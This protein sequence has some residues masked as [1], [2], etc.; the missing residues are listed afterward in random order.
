MS[1]KRRAAKAGY[2]LPWGVVSIL[3]AASTAFPA[4]AAAD[5]GWLSA[6]SADLARREYGFRPDGLDRIAAP[7]RAQGLCAAAMPDGIE[8]TPRCGTAQAAP[9]SLTLR[10]FGRESAPGVVQRARFPQADGR[11]ARLE[12]GPLSE[13]L[14]NEPRGLEHGF[15]IAAAPEGS[16]AL[17]LELAV[18]R[19]LVRADDPAGR[20]LLLLDPAGRPVL[21][22]AELAVYDAGRHALDARM[23]PI[24]GGLRIT[25]D[26]AGATFP[27]TIDPLVTSAA[28]SAES[29]QADAAFGLAVATAGDVNGDGFSDLLVGAPQFDDG[30]LLDAGAA[31]LYLGSAAGP[32]VSASW[33]ALGGV[34]G[35]GFGRAVTAAGDVNGDGF[36]DVAIGADGCD[37]G[38][39]DAGCVS[40]YYGSAAG[41]P[42]APSLVL[43]GP[44][45]GGAFGRF[46]AG[47]GDVNGD[48]FADLAVGA[49]LFDD[50]L[51]DEGKV[52][53]YLGS[54]LGLA[55]LPA[56]SAT[57]GQVEAELGAVGGAG[58]VNGD[59]FDDL[60]AGAP[61]WSAGEADEGRIWLFPGGAA[62]PG[63]VANWS[64]ES[65]SAGARFG[66]VVGT[67]GDVNGDGFA[68]LFAGA[69]RF[70]GGDLEEGAAFV[71]YGGAGS[72]SGP[73]TFQSNVAGAR[74]GFAV[75]TAGDL[76]GDGRAD[77]VV[78][79]ER[80][81]SPESEEGR[82]VAFLGTSGGLAA[83]PYWT[84]E[85][86]QAGARFA[87]VATAGDVNGDGFSDLLVGASG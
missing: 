35:D 32:A 74:A 34:A 29:D 28:W 47:A 3:V 77:L 73:W 65:D 30:A 63:A 67:A 6:V 4:A 42:A 31:F 22:Y 37:G 33:S 23:V 85:I 46:L 70:S 2:A 86:N 69:P 27:L 84:H 20:S 64:V 72:P 78:G 59:G 15:T 82:A 43:T 10:A 57:S 44:Q 11:S 8:I 55:A 16:G 26:D 13:W 66:A 87:S 36:Q 12:R 40:V 38:G 24:P 71:Y 62:G 54:A 52:F 39:T 19:A 58:D 17:V 7:N 83:T 25:I 45:T 80:W 49:P 60:V 81:S 41:L 68:D 53:V 9:I 1:M 76:N 61:R 50:P 75:A 5:P 18:G 56:W 51:A 14:H 79:L 21:R 48:G